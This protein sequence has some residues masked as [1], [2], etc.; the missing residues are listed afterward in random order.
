MFNTKVFNS[1]VGSTQHYISGEMQ[2]YAESQAGIT[3]LTGIVLIA[4]GVASSSVEFDFRGF[5]FGTRMFNDGLFNHGLNRHYFSVKMV[6]EAEAYAKQNYIAITSGDVQGI[7]EADSVIVRRRFTE[8]VL[9]GN[10]QVS[11]SPTREMLSASTMQGES[12]MHIEPMAGKFTSANMVAQ[13]ITEMHPSAMFVLKATVVGQVHASAGFLVLDYDFLIDSYGYLHPLGVKVLRDTREE[14]VPS[15][16]DYSEVIPGRHG[17]IDFGSSFNARI[18]ELHV[19]TEEGLKDKGATKR[20]MAAYLN[21]ALGARKLV[22]LDDPEAMYV[23]KFAGKIDMNQYRD[24][25]EFTIPFK[26]TNPFAISTAEYTH[27]GSGTLVNKGTFETPMVIE[28]RGSASN[29]QLTVNGQALRYTG[30]L[31]SADRVRID[32]EHM[33]VTFN[34]INALANY[35]GVFPMLKPGNNSVTAG[36]NVTFRWRARWL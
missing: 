21:P 12:W 18:L 17:E 31:S 7:A 10:S 4:E 32:T 14:F 2:G 5:G 8:R 24:W 36:S 15:T 23:V 9:L 30:T 20:A 11:L 19:V 34:G 22:F 27:V 25:F 35:N 16:R 3:R 6:S 1:S 28:I 26:M 33:T 13:G 29:P